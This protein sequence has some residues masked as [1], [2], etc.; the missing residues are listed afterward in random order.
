LAHFRSLSSLVNI[1][2]CPFQ[3]RLK[4]L[5]FTKRKLGC[6]RLTYPSGENYESHLPTPRQQGRNSSTWAIDEKLRTAKNHG[7]SPIA[8]LLVLRLDFYFGDRLSAIGDCYL[9]HHM[10]AG[11]DRHIGDGLSAI[12]DYFRSVKT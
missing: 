3:L 7:Q 12:G 6:E 10:E 5:W 4:L 8:E 1:S 2:G 9:P 11:H